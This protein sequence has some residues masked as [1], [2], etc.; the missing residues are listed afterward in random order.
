MK[1]FKNSIIIL[2][3]IPFLVFAQESKEKNKIRLSVSDKNNI[4]SAFARETENYD[5][6]L[7][8]NQD[9]E[10]QKGRIQLQ[11]KTTPA[12]LSNFPIETGVKMET[13]GYSYG[14]TKKAPYALASQ[15]FKRAMDQHIALSA[16]CKKE[17][18]LG[19]IFKLAKNSAGVFSYGFGVEGEHRRFD[20]TASQGYIVF[21]GR[22]LPAEEREKLKIAKE[23]ANRSKNSASQ[24]EFGELKEAK[25]FTTP[26]CPPADPNAPIL[27]SSDS[28][29]PC[30]VPYLQDVQE[31]TIIPFGS[32]MDSS[33]EMPSIPDTIY[34][35]NIR[36][37]QNIIRG[38]LEVA[39]E[40]P[41]VHSFKLSLKGRYAPNLEDFVTSV[42]HDYRAECRA[43]ISYPLKKDRAIAF[44]GASYKTDLNP[45]NGS[46]GASDEHDGIVDIGI[47]CK[48]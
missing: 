29:N 42:S 18:D 5:F 28:S 23:S 25:D 47:E 13:Q 31:N 6:Q 20:K 43:E 9:S 12:V 44:I 38:Y 17:A 35:S 46:I 41:E 4:G 8:A 45:S 32:S 2:F 21:D 7:G 16:G 33:V 30:H 10:K 11:L 36:E 14:L 3:S 22:A 48:F 27:M 24:G 37:A 34:F 15:D 40:S 26:V 1:L 19:S 39:Y